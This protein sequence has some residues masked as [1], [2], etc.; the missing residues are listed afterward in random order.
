MNR[1]DGCTRYVAR[2][3][4]LVE[5]LD[6]LAMFDGVIIDPG[7][8]WILL[9]ESRGADDVSE[10]ALLRRLIGAFGARCVACQ[11]IDN[12]GSL[13]HGFALCR[14]CGREVDRTM[15]R[16]GEEALP[17]FLAGRVKKRLAD[18]P[19]FIFSGSYPTYH[20]SE[21]RREERMRLAEAQRAMMTWSRQTDAASERRRLRLWEVMIA[22]A[23]VPPVLHAFLG[24]MIRRHLI[25][26][27]HERI[28][29]FIDEHPLFRRWYDRLWRAELLR[30][31]ANCG[32]HWGGLDRKALR[33]FL[34]AR[35]MQRRSCQGGCSA[36]I[37]AHPHTPR[38]PSGTS[39]KDPIRPE[40]SQ[41]SRRAIRTQGL[42]PPQAKRAVA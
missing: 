25:G 38:G 27:Q 33:A 37:L 3:R 6:R 15:S 40:M 18:R 41:G 20:E 32:G 14:E 36:P 10:P 2:A 23:H 22:R 24:H 17:L 16:H 8:A 39:R 13:I 34:V 1:R 11:A 35:I 28:D 21:R 5:R 9:N 30:L 31:Y 29:R 7:A 19:D 26:G 4:R 12:G 42:G